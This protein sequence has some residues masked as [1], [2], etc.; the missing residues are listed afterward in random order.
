MSQDPFEETKKR[1]NRVLDNLECALDQP[2]RPQVG[3]EGLMKQWGALMVESS[4]RAFVDQR[5]GEHEWPARYEGMEDPFVNIAGALQDWNSGRSSPKPNRFSPRP[6]LVDQGLSG[7][8]W[9]SITFSASKDEVEEGS[10]KAYAK[11]QQE[12]GMSTIRVSEDA[13]RR[14]RAWLF[15]NK[16]NPRAGREGYVKKLWPFL[17]KR[18]LRQNVARRP[19]LGITEELATDL[20]KTTEK[21]FEQQALGGGGRMAAAV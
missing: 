11:L 17:F 9:G 20:I 5:L 8:L 15:D 10:N 13:Y 16:G 21:Y 6:A 12:G 7:G 3:T 19:F 1:W 4:E 14:G 2:N 18:V